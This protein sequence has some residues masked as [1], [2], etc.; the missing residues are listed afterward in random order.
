MHPRNAYAARPPD[1]A[2]L[3]A[4]FPALG[5]FCRPSRPGS[6]HA[7]TI[8]WRDARALRALT[9]ALLACTFGVQWSLPEGH[10]CPTVPSRL[11]YLLWLEDLLG[12]PPAVRAGARPLRGVDVGVGASC[13]YPLLG[14]AALGWH[15]VGTDVDAAA[16]EAARGNV[17]R[18]GWEAA[19]E[20]R[21]ARARWS[22]A[23]G[24][25]ETARSEP[26]PLEAGA[27]GREPPP[28]RTACV[29]GG[30]PAPDEGG[31]DAAAPPLLGALGPDERFDFV[32]S[33]PPFYESHAE[34]AARPNPHTQREATAHELVT[35]GG[36]VGFVGQLLTESQ[37][38]CGRVRWFTSLLGKRASA[39]PL[40]RQLRAMAPVAAR[41]AVLEQGG[42][43][44]WVLAWTYDRTAAAAVA[45]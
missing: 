25:G 45:P 11:N 4:A 37:G 5:A 32:M 36:E 39:E 44:R 30:A 13:I 17:A 26:G 29:A 15:F 14:H 9:A 22:R 18:N 16:L 1:F 33:N 38:A 19:I 21:H 20:L 7:L 28:E 42:T 10:L 23:A 6:A 40:L 2:E 3:S 41:L 34:A 35:A 12:G 8:N 43:S 31:S 27:A 24:E